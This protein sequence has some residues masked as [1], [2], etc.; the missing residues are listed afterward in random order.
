MGLSPTAVDRLSL[1]QI[2][3]ATAG[4]MRA[5]GA[6]ERPAAPTP[7]EYRDMVARLSS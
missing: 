5:H 3:A 2:A 7:E 6:E 1:A 4:W